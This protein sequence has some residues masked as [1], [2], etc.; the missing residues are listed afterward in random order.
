MTTI[1]DAVTKIQPK[2]NFVTTLCTS[3]VRNTQIYKDYN[4]ISLLS[5]QIY[6]CLGI[7]SKNQK[8]A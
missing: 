6:T 2:P 4:Q 1:S 5:I 7:P 8:L 3:W